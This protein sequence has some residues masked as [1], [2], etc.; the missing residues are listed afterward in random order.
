[1]NKLTINIWESEKYPYVEV[2]DDDDF[3]CVTIMKDEL[4]DNLND[5]LEEI[6]WAKEQGATI[7]V[8][9]K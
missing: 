7:E 9:V 4:F 8:H 2:L 3:V 6:L 1:M 5:V